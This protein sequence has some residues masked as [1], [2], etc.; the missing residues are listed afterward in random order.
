[1]TEQ[2]IQELKDKF[3]YSFAKQEDVD[4]LMS[5]LEKSVNEIEEVLLEIENN[6]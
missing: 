5:S 4:K 6:N 1:M 3:K 2:E